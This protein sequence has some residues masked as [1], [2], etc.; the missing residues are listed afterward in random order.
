[1]DG[2]QYHNKSEDGKKALGGDM[3]ITDLRRRQSIAVATVAAMAA[4]L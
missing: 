1:M 2:R 4:S 3:A